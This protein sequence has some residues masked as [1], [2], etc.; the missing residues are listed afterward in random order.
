MND[1]SG[2]GLP[3]WRS[4][5]E[6][7][8]QCRRRGF[9]PWVRRSPGGGKA[10]LFQYSCLENSMDRGAW[11]APVCGVAESRTWLSDWAQR[12]SKLAAHRMDTYFAQC[13][14]V[15]SLVRVHLC[16]SVHRKLPMC[17][18]PYSDLVFSLILQPRF[19]AVGGFGMK[20]EIVA[21][22]ELMYLFKFYSSV[23][24]YLF[25]NIFSVF[26]CN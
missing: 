25:V 10:N 1:T 2:I 26:L 15:D 3:R 19:L 14:L 22:Q 5:K 24:L 7:T 9:D 12:N 23:S 16:V 6:S 4:C 13:F 11:W 18:R 8:C 17:S 20:W 21:V